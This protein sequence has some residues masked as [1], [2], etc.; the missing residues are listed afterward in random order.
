MKFKKLFIFVWFCCISV[1][2]FGFAEKDSL[3]NLLENTIQ[4]KAQFDTEKQTKIKVLKS[5]LI[6]ETETI[7][8]FKIQANLYEEYKKFQVD[9]AIF[10]IQKNLELA[11]HLE[12]DSLLTQATLQLANLYSTAG[13][14]LESQNL[15]NTI[16]KTSSQK[17]L[18]LYYA[19]KI[20]FYEHYATHG[21]NQNYSEEILAYRDSLL[22]LLPTKSIAFKIQYVQQ[23]YAKR[24]YNQAKDILSSSLKSYTTHDGNFAMM[25]YLLAEIYGIQHQTNLQKQHYCIAA[26][27]DIQNSIKDNAAIQNLALIFYH[28]GAID[29]AYKYTESA[30]EDAF[31]CNVKFRTIQITELYNII[32]TAY[33]EKEIHQKDQL[34]K[35]LWYISILSCI[36]ILTLIFVYTQNRRLKK[37]RQHLKDA[38]LKLESLNAEIQQTNLQLRQRN[39]DLSES[40]HIKEAY[41]AQFF[42][43]CSSYIDKLDGYRISL[44]KLAITKQHKE[45][46]KILKSDSLVNTEVKELY[47]NFDSIFLNLYPTFIE[48]FN[49]LLNDNEQILLKNDE[50]LNTELR[51]FALIRLGI[52]DSSQIASFLRYSLSTIYNYRTKARNKAKGSREDFENHVMQIGFSSK[53]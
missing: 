16:T 46:F 3:W 8:K 21:T 52:T 35:Q 22:G 6:E 49:S 12:N 51:I 37:T 45:L 30:V 25:H 10:Y 15:L 5:L 42:D 32:N 9:S 28:E 31:F 39:Q 17:L 47:Q 7:S 19:T 38:N 14:Y 20:E 29:K 27:T 26:I 2:L 23:L 13:N 11:K 34:Q 36:L 41:I 24:Q 33:L 44:N 40:N 4:K 53:S 48:D 43:M 18:Q 1:N 50:L